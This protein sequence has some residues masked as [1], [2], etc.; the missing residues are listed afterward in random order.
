MFTQIK[1]IIKDTASSI[2]Q[3]PTLSAD[4]VPRV[5][6]EP[7][8]LSGYRVPYRSWRYYFYSAFQLHNETLNVWTHLLG[9]CVIL[10]Q[11]R[12]YFQE[13]DINT[14]SVLSTL[15]SFSITGIFSLAISALC[16]LLHGRSP[17]VHFIAFMIDYIGAS[18]YGFGVGVASI[19]GFSDASFYRQWESI[20]IPSLAMLCFLNFLTF[21]AVKLLFGDNPHNM[22][23]K[24]MLMVSLVAQLAMCV[25]PVCH[26]YINCLYDDT[27]SMSSLNHLTIIIIIFVLDM[28]AFSLHQP[29]K[30]WPGKF[31]LVGNGHQIFHILVVLNHV[32]RLNAIHSDY[33]A[34]LLAHSN[35]DFAYIMSFMVRMILFEAL[36]LI[37]LLRFVPK[38]QSEA[39]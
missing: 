8:I 17:Y 24:Y 11:M 22:N 7:A 1:L 29:E 38:S 5:L 14:D 15:L 21:C 36:T 6:H 16:H 12:S 33:N 10:Y 28:L 34:E 19:Y 25:A 35:P 9:V 20:Y 3:Q 26:R 13:L 31:D 4:C 37:Y 18:V 27:C 39:H 2:R 23:R 32:L 30:T